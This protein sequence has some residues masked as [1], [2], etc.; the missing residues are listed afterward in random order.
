MKLWSQDND[1]KMHSTHNEGGSIGTERFIRI[2]KNKINKY[3]TSVSKINKYNNTYQSTIKI[4]PFDIKSDTYIDFNKE[5]N[6]G[7]PKFEDGDRVRISKY[8]NIFAKRYAQ[9]WF[10]EVFVI[11]KNVKNTVPWTS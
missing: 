3:M 11:K 10:E 9:N 4:K 1:I 5:N 8:K 7:D 6:K 2:L